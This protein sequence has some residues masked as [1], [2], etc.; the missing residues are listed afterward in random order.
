MEVYSAGSGII[1]VTTGE[2]TVYAINW[3]TGDIMKKVGDKYVTEWY[4]N[5]MFNY[6]FQVEDGVS[7]EG[8]IG[9][10]GQLTTGAVGI[11]IMD[12]AAYEAILNDIVESY[13]EYGNMAAMTPADGYN[14]QAGYSTFGWYNTYGCAADAPGYTAYAYLEAYD[15]DGDDKA[16]YALFE[17]YRFGY[18]Y[19]E[20]ENCDKCVDQYGRAVAHATV[21]LEAV[22]A[23]YVSGWSYN[24]RGVP[25]YSERYEAQFVPCANHPRTDCA[26]FV[27]G[28]EP[29]TNA[30]GKVVD[31]YV[32][33]GVDRASN[34]IKI[35]KQITKQ[36]D[37]NQVD[38][39]SYVATGRVLG[40][41]LYNNT[42]NV[43][44]KDIPFINPT[45]A[46]SALVP[47]HTVDNLGIYNGWRADFTAFMST[48]YN[49]YITYVLIDGI[50]VYAEPCGAEAS[51]W[52]VVEGVRGLDTDN[53]VVINGY[54]TEDLTLDTFRIE[55]VNGWTDGDWTW[56]PGNNFEAIEAISTPG[57][58]LKITSYDAAN[59]LY[60]VAPTKTSDLA[61][62][63]VTIAEADNLWRTNTITD[64]KTQRMSEND[65]YV[66]IDSRLATA[67]FMPIYVYEGILGDGWT[68]TG[69][70][71]VGANSLK[72]ANVSSVTLVITDA[73]NVVGFNN[74][75][76]ETGY[77][78][79]ERLMVV[80]AGYNGAG[81][82]YHINGTS[83]YVVIGTDLLT[84]YK[85]VVANVTNFVPEVGGIYK[86]VS[87]TI[88][89]RDG[90]S[91]EEFFNDVQV[92][93]GGHNDLNTGKYYVDV[94]EITRDDLNYKKL[95]DNVI[96]PL[97]GYTDI[98]HEDLV[99]QYSQYYMA[100]ET[101]GAVTLGTLPWGD[102]AAVEVLLVY[103][104]ETQ[105]AVVYYNAETCTATP[106]GAGAIAQFE[107][108]A[109]G[110]SQL[111]VAFVGLSGLQGNGS[112]SPDI[113]TI[114]LYWV[115]AT[116]ANSFGTADFTVTVK[117][118][119]GSTIV[120]NGTPTF[121]KNAA[122]QIIGF[123]LDAS[124][125]NFK[126]LPA[127]DYQYF[128]LEFTCG[129]GSYSVVVYTCNLAGGFICGTVAHDSAM[130][131]VFSLPC[132]KLNGANLG[133]S[134]Q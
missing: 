48:L 43:D 93:F 36:G 40:Y 2:P 22:E 15:L 27:E 130:V 77:I 119:D 47:S 94:V 125:I 103:D 128:Y 67:G 110:N 18:L 115:N 126:N 90:M 26:Q 113:D 61:G 24:A 57:T 16:E 50:I 79:V 84:G 42:I 33:Y 13:Y 6:Y 8:V 85:G 38:A 69:K 95:S 114:G 58:L 30:N 20:T 112:F 23:P 106:A 14:A 21:V 54:S 32:I 104:A 99:S 72:N 49:Q 39:D 9:S 31:G 60:Y 44:G 41:S 92:A 73:T 100:T 45:L 107:Y 76:H 64:G 102:W 133:A 118:A 120:A 86:T 74:E 87:G 19:N 25:F 97:F 63:T 7:L 70:V 5:S 124:A 121:A 98:A 129:T 108:L 105:V 4:W 71:V 89:D 82:D 34:D 59:D 68:V 123:D 11:T 109:V 91:W 3:E 55:V 46:S 127:G 81:S 78:L 80:E 117:A 134:A 101:E 88:L 62:T 37:K 75:T 17:E 29:I 65:K 132:S 51:E 122:G 35:I 131:T 56:F 66:I 10:N 111:H 12:E 96:A 1:G 28:Y 53:K 116:D 83:E 52:I